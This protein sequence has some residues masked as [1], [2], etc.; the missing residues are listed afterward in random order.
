MEQLVNVL[1]DISFGMLMFL[2]FGVCVLTTLAAWKA[3]DRWWHY[4]LLLVWTLMFSVAFT[5][6][7]LDIIFLGGD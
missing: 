4:A 6:I 3:S 1:Y 5:A 7:G 2:M